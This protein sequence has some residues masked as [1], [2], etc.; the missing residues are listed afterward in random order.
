VNGAARTIYTIVVAV[1]TAIMSSEHCR[2]N[3]QTLRLLSVS[4]P[5]VVKRTL[6]VA[7]DSLFKALR[8]IIAN[9]LNGPVHL[10]EKQKKS[11]LKHKKSLYLI[12][13]SDKVAKR[14]LK[15][16]GHSFLSRILPPALETLR[17]LDG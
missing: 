16:D 4:K 2:D 5:A 1:P 3:L 10:T 8:E 15:A 14:V 6:A 13:E 9:V 12:V 11:L 7:D 17:R